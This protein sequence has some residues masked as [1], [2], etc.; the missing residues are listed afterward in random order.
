[1]G[2]MVCSVSPTRLANTQPAQVPADSE[3]PATHD[4]FPIVFPPTGVCTQRPKIGR[5]TMT[6]DPEFDACHADAAPVQT[7][8]RIYDDQIAPL[9]AQILDICKTH[10]IACVATF[11]V[12]S[13]TD[14]ELACSSA[15]VGPEFLTDCGPELRTMLRRVLRNTG[16]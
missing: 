10:H 5:I 6:T 4:C 13:E 2:E 11:G 7:K 16:A 8:E 3:H 1:M 12:P 9:M 14:A 15:L